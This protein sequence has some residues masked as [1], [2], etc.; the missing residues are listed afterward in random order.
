MSARLEKTCGKY[1]FVLS[2]C[3]TI[4]R[5]YL[6]PYSVEYTFVIFE[7]RE[8]LLRKYVL[9]KAMDAP[10]HICDRFVEHIY[11]YV[12]GQSNYFDTMCFNDTV[13]YIRESMMTIQLS[14]F[15][16]V[17]PEL[18][19]ADQYDLNDSSPESGHSASGTNTSNRSY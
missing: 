2:V 9:Q 4:H 5:I 18:E 16:G 12:M 17:Y 3:H 15:V 8:Y 19:N 10:I 7:V 14:G 11:S 13:N 6:D 1:V